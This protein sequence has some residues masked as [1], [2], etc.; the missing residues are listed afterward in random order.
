MGLPY[1]E[2]TWFA[3]PMPTGG[4]AVGVVARAT[5]G[6]G[7]TLCYFFGPRT[8]AVPTL[9]DVQSNRPNDAVRV[10]RV[11]DLGLVNGEWTILGSSPSW[12]RADRPM[13]VFVRADPL[14]GRS[15]RVEY[16]DS[17]PSELVSESPLE[18][19]DPTLD[20]DSMYGYAAAADKVDAA[21]TTAQR[22]RGSNR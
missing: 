5:P 6:G 20:L 16:S 21:L 14:S 18:R 12:D 19:L 8:R 3:D 4:Y 11:G 10:L 2:G 1:R 22:Q 7:V 13:P 9:R 15:R 17:D